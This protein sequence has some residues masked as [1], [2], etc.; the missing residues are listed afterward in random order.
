MNLNEPSTLVMNLIALHSKLQKRIG[1]ALT[2]HGLGLSEYLVLQ[3]LHAAPDQK[4]RRIDL[5]E[6]VGMSPSGITRLLNPME[7]IGLIGKETNPRDARVSLVSLSDAGKRVYR[8][9][10]LAFEQASVNLIK[11]LNEQETSTLSALAKSVLE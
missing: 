2:M 10:R 8:E 11:P 4:M 5:A 1:G 7:K 3:R 9:A 6:Q